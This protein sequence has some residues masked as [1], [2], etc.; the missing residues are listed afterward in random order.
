MA[1]QQGTLMT[2]A[3]IDLVDLLFSFQGRINRGKYWLAALLY[4]IAW[5]VFGFIAWW[6]LSISYML[7]ATIGSLLLLVTMVSGVFVGIKRLHDRDKGGWWLALFYLV[8]GI[9]EGIGSSIGGIGFVLSLAG[10]AISVWAFVELG[11]LRGTVGP[12]QY[13]PDPLEGRA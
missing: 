12:N 9:L 5:I 7:G 11:C 13:G 3:G 8:P 10:F 4:V 1:A 6:L 2:I